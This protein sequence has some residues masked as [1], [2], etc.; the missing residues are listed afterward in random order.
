MPSWITAM[1]L[2][3]NPGFMDNNQADRVNTATMDDMHCKK[4]Q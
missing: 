3:V 1:L 2:E 4:S